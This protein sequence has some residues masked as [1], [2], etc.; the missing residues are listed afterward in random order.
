LVRVGTSF[1][2][3]RCGRFGL[4]VRETFRDVLARGFAIVRMSAYW[5]EIA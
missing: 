5:D 4:P 2:P 1:S 3:R